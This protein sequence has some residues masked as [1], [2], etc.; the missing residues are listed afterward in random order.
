M[1]ILESNRNVLKVERDGLAWMVFDGPHKT[2]WEQLCAGDWEPELFSF[3][4]EHLKS[5]TVF[6]KHS[7]TA[8][9]RE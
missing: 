8:A 4:K 9:L 3:L 6:R 5:N 2:F 7:P 1:Q